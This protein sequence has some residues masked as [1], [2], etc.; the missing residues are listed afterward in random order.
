M[1]LLVQSSWVFLLPLSCQYFDFRPRRQ[2]HHPLERTHNVVQ[3]ATLGLSSTT[4][5][6]AAHLAYS[7]ASCD[8]SCYFTNLPERTMEEGL[9]TIGISHTPRCKDFK[10]GRPSII[11]VGPCQMYVCP[12]WIGS[13]K[14]VERQSPLI[15]TLAVAFVFVMTAAVF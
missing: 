1:S 3:I 8:N 15:T 5:E 12:L 11:P 14:K 7:L 4:Y 10:S 6:S 9:V 2:R 13:T